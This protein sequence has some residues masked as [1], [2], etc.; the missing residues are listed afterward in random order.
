MISKILESLYLKVFVN[1]V[2]NKYETNVAIE[3]H[4]KDG[5]QSSDQ[6]SFGTDKLDASVLEF[7]KSY[8]QE[9]PYYYI[10]ILDTSPSQG[11]IPTCEKSKLS[12]YESVDDSEYKC[13]KKSWTYYTS[14]NDLYAIEKNFQEIGVDF[15][16]SPFSVLNKFFKDK[17]D[18]HMA[19]YVLVQDTATIVMVFDNSKLLFGQ[20]LSMENGIENED[21]IIDDDD[22]IDLDLEEGIDLEDIDVVDDIEALEDFGD[23]EDLDSLED[24]AE[25]SETKDVEEEFYQDSEEELASHDSEGFNEDYQRFTLIQSAI[26]RFYKDGRY[27]S[28]F[29]ENIYIADAV[30]VTSDLKR[31]LEE[32]MFLSVYIRHIDLLA[33]VCELAREEIA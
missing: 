23:I 33:E 17:I 19:M 15:V 7:I 13:H 26:N 22:E 2:V 20:L 25:F 10:S 16:F 31:Y 1:I 32:E 21:L 29:I 5:M 4:S 30:G 27:E 24:I 6:D 3:L 12:Y 14:K 11:V 18:S 8:T 28:K 9:S